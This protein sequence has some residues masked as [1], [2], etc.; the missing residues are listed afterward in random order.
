MAKGLTPIELQDRRQLADEE[1]M[2]P[3]IELKES[4]STTFTEDS[5]LQEFTAS[6]PSAYARFRLS[7]NPRNPMPLPGFWPALFD[8]RGK[9]EL[10]G[11]EGKIGA[12]DG[13]A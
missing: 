3:D 10:S 4:I 2:D 12:K 8:Y 13:T 1:K 9:M 5:E 11:V 7:E 6:V